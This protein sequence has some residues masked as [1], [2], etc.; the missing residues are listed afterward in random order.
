M[1][2]TIQVDLTRKASNRDHS[3]LPYTRISPSGKELPAFLSRKKGKKP[4]SQTFASALQGM[5]WTPAG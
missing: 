4:W 5:A 2:L 3:H 1:L